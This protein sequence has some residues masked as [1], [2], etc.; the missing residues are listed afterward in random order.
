MELEFND[1]EKQLWEIL[2]YKAPLH[3]KQFAEPSIR[4]IYF[5]L[6]ER[7]NPEDDYA[8][9][10]KGFDSE[11]IKDLMR[12]ITKDVSSKR[13][14]VTA[15]KGIDYLLRTSPEEA[16]KV[17]DEDVKSYIKFHASERSGMLDYSISVAN[18]KV[19]M[20][21]PFDNIASASIKMGWGFD[22]FVFYFFSQG[23][24][25]VKTLSE[26]LS[27]REKKGFDQVFRLKVL[28]K[29]KMYL[30]RNKTQADP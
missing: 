6:A 3:P 8:C 7:M 22:E 13:G 25:A 24:V 16:R 1:K 21:P 27:E 4:S 26:L 11:G 30:E 2:K 14:F 10:M 29:F 15:A 17:A 23:L 18:N 19:I 9:F 12:N 5:A 20:P 28:P